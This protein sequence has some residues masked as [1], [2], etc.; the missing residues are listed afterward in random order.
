MNENWFSCFFA[1]V[2]GSQLPA[3][4]PTCYLIY[5][6]YDHSNKGELTVKEFF[7]VLKIQN[8][9]EISL[10]DVQRFLSFFLSLKAFKVLLLTD[11]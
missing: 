5:F 4:I 11:S 6:R 10:A 8:K 9:I 7:N 3:A 1:N 2:L